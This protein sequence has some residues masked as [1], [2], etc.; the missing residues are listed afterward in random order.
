MSGRVLPL[1]G[2]EHTVVDAL[3]PFYVNGTLQGDEL[4]RVEQ[5][6]GG[7][8]HCRR[9]VDWL[10]DVF[11]AC[12]EIAPIPETPL[13]DTGRI[14]AITGG[15]PASAR[16]VGS[17]GWRGRVSSGWA[18][19]QPWARMLM[20]AQLAGLA[21]L[22]AM[23]VSETR[24]EAPYRTLGAQA[25]AAPLGDSIAVMFDPAITEG[26][27]RLLLDGVGARI[28]DGP[29]ATAAFVLAV[30]AGHSDAAVRKLR[31][32]RKVL[33]AEPLGAQAER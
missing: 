27:M 24:D 18:A 16:R 22:G 23:L 25:R 17:G 30:P 32:E 14:P 15:L 13:A 10:R 26:E 11:A 19:T 7:C 6:L 20:A 28:V 31:T 9:E 33:F 12:E 5:H 8:E 29:T 2:S 21:V 4:D 1:K 3:L